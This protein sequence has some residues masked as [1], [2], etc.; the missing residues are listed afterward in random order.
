MDQFERIVVRPEV[1]LGQPCIR[2]TRL[3]VYVILDAV[4]SGSSSEVLMEEFPFLENEDI[5]AALR[6]AAR[7]TEI[8]IEV[9]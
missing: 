5:S 6:Y 9:A 4:A 1:M 8:G 2:D 3:P 7:L